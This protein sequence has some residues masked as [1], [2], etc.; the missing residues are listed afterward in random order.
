MH[1]GQQQRR[2]VRARTHGAPHLPPL[3]TLG[4]ARCLAGQCS[5]RVQVW[6]VRSA[7]MGT[8]SGLQH[9]CMRACTQLFSK[10]VPVLSCCR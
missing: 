1:V 3:Q 9:Q 4:S 8:I 2:V 10:T 5:S 7:P 6:C